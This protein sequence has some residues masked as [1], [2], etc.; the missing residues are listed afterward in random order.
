MSEVINMILIILQITTTIT[1]NK[2]PGST[3]DSTMTEIVV[4]L[5]VIMKDDNY[6]LESTMISYHNRII[7]IVIEVIVLD[8]I[9]DKII[10]KMRI[11]QTD[12]STMKRVLLL[13]F[14]RMVLMT[15][16]VW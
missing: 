15:E 3:V 16:P 7:F 2:P 6:R 1:I 12:E 9:K 11:D 13:L 4:Q 5:I 8:N 10:M 14:V